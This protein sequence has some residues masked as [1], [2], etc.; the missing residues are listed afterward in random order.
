MRLL[1]ALL[2][3]VNT[4]AFGREQPANWT[5]L[6]LEGASLEAKKYHTLRDPY[7]PEEGA[8]D[9]VGGGS[10]MERLRLLGHRPSGTSLFWQNRLHFSGTESQIR[11]GG[12][13]FE[14]GL[15]KK[16]TTT[17]PGWTGTTSLF[18]YHHSQHVMERARDIRAFPVENSTILLIE[19]RKK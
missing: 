4:V 15:S 17:M 5:F 16:D 3:I 18:Y 7:I 2:L 12:W 1:L 9:W 8:T 13:E 14:L 11:Q 10:F 6:E 19:W